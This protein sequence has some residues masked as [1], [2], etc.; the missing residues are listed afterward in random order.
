MDITRLQP[1]IFAL[2]KSVLPPHISLPDAIGETLNIS[3][4]S[5]YR[6]IRGEKPLTIDE[7]AILARHYKFSIDRILALQ[8]ESYI[9]SGKLANAHDHVF[10]KWLETSLNQFENMAKYPNAHIYYLAKD[11]PLSHFFQTP[12]LASFKFFFWQ[13]SILQYHELRGV[14]FS[15]GKME[16]KSKE[17]AAKIV[18][19]YNKIHSSELWAIET[20]NSVLRQIQYYYETGLFENKSDP[21][22]LCDSFESLINHLE[23]Q[24]EEGVKFSFGKSPLSGNGNYYIYNNE[25]IIGNNNVL[26]DLGDIKVTY[27]NH[28]SINYVS[29]YDKVFNDYHLN[30]TLNMIS[31]SEPLHTVNEKRRISFF[32]HV[33]QKIE[34]TRR[35]TS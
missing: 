8:T 24:A 13:K 2:I 17:L 27:L 19:V 16:D 33:R 23:R 22:H 11:L 4:D 31:K 25:L 35:K 30:A 28:S 18:N 10:D 3:N 6:R 9:F 20:V 5:V 29:T 21:G 14:K 1:E 7:L 34:S 32:N 12:E 15:L 26:A